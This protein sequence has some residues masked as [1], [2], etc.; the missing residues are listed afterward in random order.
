ME[1]IIFDNVVFSPADS[2]KKPW[3]DKFYHCEGVSAGAAVNGTFPA[4][5]C[6]TITPDV[7]I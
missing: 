4:P 5:P 2:S 3:G 7:V 6:F 1:G